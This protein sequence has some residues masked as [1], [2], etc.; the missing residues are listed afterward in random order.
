MLSIF[1]SSTFPDKHWQAST[2]QDLPEDSHIVLIPADRTDPHKPHILHPTQKR[3]ILHPV[4]QLQSPTIHTT[5]LRCANLA[6]TLDWLHLQLRP[7]GRR[8]LAVEV[9]LIDANGT[10]AVVRAASFTVRF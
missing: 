3:S 4:V 1:S 7:L 10:R 2:D 6:I 9:G 5:F 8:E